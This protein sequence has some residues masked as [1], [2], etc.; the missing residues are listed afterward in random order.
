LQILAI[1]SLSSTHFDANSFL[2]YAA[3]CPVCVGFAGAPY[4]WRLACGYGNLP[5]FESNLSGG[6]YRP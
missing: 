4:R 6:A 3:M 2:F 5:T 1:A